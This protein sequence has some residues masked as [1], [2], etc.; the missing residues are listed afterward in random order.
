MVFFSYDE[1]LP[2]LY[3]TNVFIPRKGI[4]SLFIVSRVLSPGY[5][6]L[7]QSMDIIFQ[8]WSAIDEPQ[9]EWRSSWTSV[10]SAFFGHLRQSLSN[11]HS[12]R[13]TVRMPALRHEIVSPSDMNEFMAHWDRLASSRTWKRLQLCVPCDWYE[14][15]Q[16]QAEAQS[17]WQ[18]TET[19]WLDRSPLDHGC[20]M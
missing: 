12:L 7:I 5:L 19:W 20:G 13:L 4:D 10:Y 14:I 3:G 15:L 11:L 18:L 6:S 2:I 8:L 16:E 17:R 1:A 9:E